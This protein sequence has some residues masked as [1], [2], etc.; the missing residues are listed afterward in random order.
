[1][2]YDPEPRYPVVA[3]GV[4]VGYEALAV[5]VARRRPRVLAVDGPAALP[6]ERFGTSLREALRAAGLHVRI[7]DVRRSLAPWDEIQRRTAAAELPGDPVFARVFEG[8]LR[9]LFDEMPS[10]ERTADEDMALVVGPGSALTDHDVL[11]YAD[12]P[13]RMALEAV[14]RGRAG[15]VGQAPGQPGSEQRLL[16]V[17]WPMLD[18]H[19]QELAARIDRYIDASAPDAP[20]SLDGDALRRSLAALAVRPFRTRPTFLPG[21]WGGQWLRRVLGAPTDA[22]N[23]AWSYELITPESGILL[24]ESE[25]VEAGFEL[26]MAGHAEDVLGRAVAER[27]GRSFPIRFDYLDTLEGGHLS[28]QCHPSEAYMQETFGL[29]YTQ[30]ETYY[31]MVTT[32]GA[33][34]FLGLREDADLEA[35]EAEAE[36]AEQP[37]EAFEPERYLQTHRAEQHRLYLIPAGTPH[38]S[39]AGNVVLEISATPYLYTL[40]FYDWLRRD[41][42]GGLRSV[43]LRH[44]F[45][46][47]DP[48][49]RGEAVREL[50]PEPAVVRR[51][52]GWSELAL[53]RAPELF[54]AVHRLDFE[55]EIADETSGR[56]HALNLAAGDEVEVRT[57][58]GDV[59]RL[60]YA[61]TIVIPAAVGEYRLRRVRGG[62]CKVVKAFVR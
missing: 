62:P 5:E 12:L 1:V 18:R 42:D 56:F 40:R 9:E 14:Q 25:P 13:K 21:P 3:G 27:F 55:A 44:A 15:N 35:F 17:D 6:W 16:F 10:A 22:P 11:W 60:S 33:K 32:P 47:L 49:R 45:S 38:A 57:A 30:H 34:I 2:T 31:V 50:M 4:E 29:P 24:G 53:G 58:A 54:F 43:H 51:G 26:L 48:G 52:A 28:I 61:E 20:R 7:Q 23:L 37:G 8:S 46:N 41:L 36:L 59:H 19:K 39:G